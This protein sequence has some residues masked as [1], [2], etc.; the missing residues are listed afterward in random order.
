MPIAAVPAYLGKDFKHASP[1]LRFGML[2]PIWTTRQD[3]EAEVRERA[4]ARS[5]EG[6]EVAETLRNRGM[7]AAIGLLRNRERNPLPG[8]WDKN[9]S[10]ARKAWETIKALTS[11][12]QARM[13]AL[14]DRQTAWSDLIP[15]ETLLRLDAKATSPFTTGLGNEHPLENGFAFLWP[16]GLPYLPGS[17]VKGVLRRA[18]EELASGQWGG[19]AGW[20]APGYLLRDGN[21]KPVCDDRKQPIE[22]SLIDVLFGR[23][24][25]S[26]DSNAMRGALTFWDVVP[27]IEGQELLVEVMT[28]HQGHYYQQKIERKQGNSVTPHDS[29][30]PIPISFLTVP[31][32]S[33]FCFVVVC[34]VAHLR[35]L[36]ATR[37][38]AAPDLLQLQDDGRP[39][40]QHLLCAAFE[41]AFQWLGFGAKTAVGY[42]ALQRDTEIEARRKREREKQ[43]AERQQQERL[44][45]MTQAMREIEDFKERMEKRFEELRGKKERANQR[46]HGWARELAKRA[47]EASDWTPEEKS[48]AADAIEE[49]LPKVVQVDIKDERKKL[50]LGALRGM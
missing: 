39:Y 48:A 42:G 24:P 2:L 1:G 46:E 37:K 33:R 34:D 26:G 29:G 13:K 7:D 10:A 49:W 16:Y 19:H 5:G 38:E 32:G 14:A 4:E 50:K 47:L 23:E 3:Q 31:P 15:G 30:Q 43:E 20:N 8:L 22:L 17:G 45:A 41:H 6:H 25:P 28:P 18:A 44:A 35:R 9:D 11:D 36:T 27:Q 12:D 21:G 40:W